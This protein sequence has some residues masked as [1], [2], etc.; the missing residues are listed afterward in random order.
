M[1][2]WSNLAENGLDFPIRIDDESRAFGA[3]VFFPI[4]ALFDPYAVGLHDGAGFVADERKRKRMLG[5]EFGVALRRINADAENQ[6]VLGEDFGMPV[7]DATGLRG[8]SGRVIL[9]IK[10]ENDF[11]AAKAGEADG[12]AFGEGVANCYGGEI[13]S[14]IA[15]LEF[16]FHE[17]R[18]IPAVGEGCKETRRGDFEGSFW[19]D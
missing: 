12:L 7:A 16:G 9:W 5:E 15:G 19:N 8:A 2:A 10:I 11:F 13:W 4:H 1:G 14:G 3:H 18:S 17:G 6:G